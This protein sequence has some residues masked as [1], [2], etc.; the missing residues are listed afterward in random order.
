MNIIIKNA[1]KRNDPKNVIVVEI[2]T[3]NDKTL[4]RT[5]CIVP[6]P[7]EPYNP[8]IKLPVE[9]NHSIIVSIDNQSGLK[10]IPG[11]NDSD[12][13]VKYLKRLPNFPEDGGN[14]GEIEDPFDQD[15]FLRKYN[16]KATKDK[17]WSI[18]IKEPVKIEEEDASLGKDLLAETHTVEVGDN[19][20]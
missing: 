7:N 3:K 2:L 9:D 10:N 17:C 5:H 19:D 13:T 20:Q 4:Y 12:Y 6:L 14:D 11:D 18:L 8:S 16:K 1:F 15:Y